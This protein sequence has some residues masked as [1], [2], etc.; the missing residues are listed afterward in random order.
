MTTRAELESA[1]A[2]LTAREVLPPRRATDGGVP[3]GTCE[4]LDLFSLCDHGPDEVGPGPWAAVVELPDGSVVGIPLVSNGSDD[5]GVRR[6]LPGDG[7][8]V[9]LVARFASSRVATPALAAFS[10]HSV[11]ADPPAS[12]AAERAFDVDQTHDSVVVGD[13]VVVKWG[14]HLAPQV[15]EPPAV[16][17]LRQLSSTGFSEMPR[18]RGQL[19]WRDRSGAASGRPTRLALLASAAEYLPGAQDGWDWYVADMLDLLAGGRSLDTALAPAVALGGLVA[20]FHVAL[21]TVTSWEP[22]PVGASTPSDAERWRTHAL[23]RLDEAVSV[24][25]GEAG[26]RLQA[27]V[28]RAG[29]A[30]QRLAAVDTTP[31]TLVHGD[32]HVGQVLRWDGGYALNDFDG[33]PVLSAE[34]QRAKQPPVRDVAGMLQSLDHVGR[35]A[36]RRTQRAQDDGVERWIAGAKDAF[37]DAYRSQ[38]AEAGRSEL[39]DERLLLPFAVEQ[40][41]REYVYAARHLPLWTHVPDRALPALLRED[42]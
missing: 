21:A 7:V 41:C 13:S 16:R 6:A 14:V 40:E 26:E 23:A 1:V 39:L 24:T 33:N 35:I 32:L 29:K 22:D 28:P 27:L 34:Q 4:L 3:D 11:E 20:R 19:L 36:S 10:L 2:R 30:L 42:D 17:L 31:L 9:A 18:P 5:F 15:G 12:T 25:A 37:L 8:S 38:L